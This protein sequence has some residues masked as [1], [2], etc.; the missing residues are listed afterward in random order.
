MNFPLL[1][2]CETYDFEKLFKD[3][4]YAYFKTGA[5][6]LNI[7]GVRSNNNNRVTNDFD[8][9]IVVIYNTA[10][11]HSKRFTA[12]ITTE[13]GLYYLSRNLST[14]KGTAILVP[15]Q[16]RGCWEI[17]KHKGKYNALCQKKAVKVYRDK[18]RDE[19][20]D[21]NPQTI[22]SGIFGINIHKSAAFGEST[23]VDQWS[24]GCQVF[25]RAEEF[26]SFMR[27]CEEQKARY[28]NSFTYTLINETDLL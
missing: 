8:D 10:A 24:A 5:Y 3:K 6:N 12:F 9:V 17:G 14:S 26:K 1:R 28:G 15:A 25:R 13:P 27:L 23:K 20:Y 4:G 2:K 19:I 22:E 7:I 11:G 18:N 21:L 16:Y